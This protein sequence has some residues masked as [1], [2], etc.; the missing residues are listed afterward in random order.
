[1]KKLFVILLAVALTLSLA[2]VASAA[3]FSPYVGGE[4]QLT[5][6]SNAASSDN[7]IFAGNGGNSMMKAYVQGKVEDADTNTWAQ[8]GAKLTCWTW[9]WNNPSDPKTPFGWDLLY[10]AGVKQVGG[11]MDIQYSTDDYETTLRGQT[12]LYRDG[13]AKFGGDPF[14][15]N[16][17]NHAFGFD[18]NTDNMTVNVGVTAGI[19]DNGYNN[20]PVVYDGLFK[21]F[22]VA[23]TFKFDAGKVHV[24]YASLGTNNSNMIVG[25]EFKLGFGT[26]KA[27]YY[28]VNTATSTSTFQAG[29]SFDEMKLAATLMYDMKQWNPAKDSTIGLGVEYSGI[30]K[31]TLGMKYFMLDDAA[32]EVYGIVK[33]GIFDVRPGYAKQSGVQNGFFYLALHAGLW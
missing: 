30:D 31:L 26:L 25:G 4:L 22:V 28:M 12:P 9:I 29:V 1:M 13:I 18:V 32:Y 14:F 20:T 27:D 16:R 10:S 3:T 5:Y 2:A 21:K 15:V 8:I 24:G 6:M 23:G 7:P 11:V 19:V 33:A 17:L